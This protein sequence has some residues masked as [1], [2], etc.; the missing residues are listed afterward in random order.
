M[1]RDLSP[2]STNEA[3]GKPASSPLNL[4]PL[5]KYPT[6]VRVIVLCVR[7]SCVRVTDGVGSDE[8]EFLKPEVVV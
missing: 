2:P 1:N 4:L 8:V 3:P 5:V 7:I 6:R